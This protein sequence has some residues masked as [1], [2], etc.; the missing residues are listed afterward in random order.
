M[1]RKNWISA[2]WTYIFGI[3]TDQ[4]E[5]DKKKI[6]FYVPRVLYAMVYGVFVLACWREWQS[7]NKLLPSLALVIVLYGLPRITK[8]K[9]FGVVDVQGPAQQS[10]T[11]MVET[12]QNGAFQMYDA[13]KTPHETKSHFSRTFTNPD[14]S[15]EGSSNQNKM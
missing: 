14:D 4:L 9:L 11:P 15:P 6:V 3:P 10:T 13:F 2:S 7:P 8:L 1:S 5:P 12:S